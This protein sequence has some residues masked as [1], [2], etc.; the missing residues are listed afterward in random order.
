MQ[1]LGN[2][3]S[4][5]RLRI[6]HPND[7]LIISRNQHD[8]GAE[9]AVFAGARLKQKSIVLIY[10]PTILDRTSGVTGF[11]WQRLPT[12]SG[13]LAAVMCAGA[14]PAGQSRPP[15]LARAVARAAPLAAPPPARRQLSTVRR[16]LLRT[17][18]SKGDSTLLAIL[19]VHSMLTRKMC[20]RHHSFTRI[21]LC[22]AA[23][24][25]R[26]DSSTSKTGQECWRHK[27]NQH[28]L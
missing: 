16:A 24:M 11:Q 25:V 10:S 28:S 22:Q 2:R 7:R 23:E 21:C 19:P 15:Q 17:P 20:D 5:A 3:E 27:M 14:L 4:N 9:T 13:R 18:Q 1:A 26:S 12:M 8:I 6:W